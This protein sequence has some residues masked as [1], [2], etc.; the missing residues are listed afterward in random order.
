MEERREIENLKL[1]YLLAGLFASLADLAVPR[2]PA[3]VG[4]RDNRMS[5]QKDWRKD[6]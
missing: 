1:A 4:G 2:E 5:G 6:L 3:R